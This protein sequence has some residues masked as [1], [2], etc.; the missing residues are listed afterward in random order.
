MSLVGQ[1]AVLVAFPVLASA[2][3]AIVAALRPP[4][5]RIVSGVQHFAAGVVMAALVGEI[6]PELRAEGHVDWTVAGFLAGT[7]LVLGL[8][9]YGRHTEAHAAGELPPHKPRFGAWRRQ[10]VAAAGAKT[11]PIGMLGAV[12]V[13]L[14]L[15]GVL[16]GLG[17]RL[18]TTQGV[19]LTIA[20]TLEILFLGLSVVSELHEGGLA[21]RHAVMMTIGLGL[22][23][24]VGAIGAALFLGGVSTNIMSFVLAF[25]AAALLYLVVEELLVEAHEERESVWLGAMFF[26]GFILIYVLA[27]MEM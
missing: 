5:P 10:A 22:T 7:A 23:T 4:G 11:L 25:G 2:I 15:D 21:R 9:A 14:L 12:A 27:S 6:M 20:L 13:D 8:G 16:V 17:V 19:I 18:G 3:G 1:A 24:A 26:L